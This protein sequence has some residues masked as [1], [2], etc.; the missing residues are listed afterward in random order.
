[1]GTYGLKCVE[2]EDQYSEFEYVLYFSDLERI[3]LHDQE[4]NKS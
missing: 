3:E 2:A 4:S 1:M